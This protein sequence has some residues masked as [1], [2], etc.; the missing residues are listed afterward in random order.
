MNQVS[1]WFVAFGLFGLAVG[2]DIL[3]VY[4]AWDDAPGE[5]WYAQLPIYAWFAVVGLGAFA[6]FGRP[7]VEITNTAVD[8]RNIFR[9]VHIPLSTITDASTDG[10]YLVIT[11]GGRKYR[12]AGTESPNIQICAGISAS[13]ALNVQAAVTAGAQSPTDDLVVQR[14]RRPPEPPER[15]LITLWLLYPLLAAAADFLSIGPPG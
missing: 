7:R 13:A 11:A 5:P 8:L 1:G 14:W 15:L 2:I 4:S 3:H 10:K 12:A 9:D 6:V